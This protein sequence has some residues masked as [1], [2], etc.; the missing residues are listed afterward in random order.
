[1]TVRRKIDLINQLRVVSLA[2]SKSKI[3][4]N[5]DEF[6]YSYIQSKDATMKN[7]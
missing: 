7:T 6:L 1:M 3:S 4:T 5:T 2:D